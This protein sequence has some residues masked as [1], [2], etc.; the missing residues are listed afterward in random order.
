VAAGGTFSTAFGYLLVLSFPLGFGAFV[1]ARRW[2]THEKRLADLLIP[3][4][5]KKWVGFPPVRKG[6]SPHTG[7]VK[8]MD[9]GYRLLAG[10]A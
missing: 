5:H 2:D 6:M 1:H 10:L 3:N 8:P 7:S 4:P 9:V